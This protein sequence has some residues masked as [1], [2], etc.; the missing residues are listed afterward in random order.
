MTD[1]FINSSKFLTDAE[2]NRLMARLDGDNSWE[3][4]AI[5][6][7]LKYGMRSGELLQLRSRDISRTAKS[8]WVRGTKGSRDR[9]FP[10]PPDLLSRLLAI[11]SPVDDEP[12]FAI[13]RFQLMRIW[14]LYKPTMGKTL[15]CLRHT[16]AVRNYA[17]TKD[18][19]KV[20]RLLG[21]R[22]IMTTMK[23]QDF[24]YSLETFKEMLDV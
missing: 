13:N 4:L 2:H 24:D 21:H 9:E 15:H 5:E 6:L 16:C 1:Q 11:K 14:D 7:L 8:M 23:Y 22:S 10:L 18:L 12:I 20:Q 17:K 19:Q 3:A